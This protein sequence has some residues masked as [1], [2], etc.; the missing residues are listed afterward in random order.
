M[1]GIFIAIVGLPIFAFGIWLLYKSN[2]EKTKRRN[3]FG[4]EQYKSLGDS[5]L[6]DAKVGLYNFIGIVLFSGGGFIT[7]VGIMFA[8]FPTLLDSNSRPGHLSTNAILMGENTVGVIDQMEEESQKNGENNLNSTE[9]TEFYEKISNLLP[10]ICYEESEA[11]RKRN[12][13]CN[14][15]QI[16]QEDIDI[17]DMISDVEASEM[18]YTIAQ[19]DIKINKLIAY[20]ETYKSNRI[21]FLVKHNLSCEEDRVC[22]GIAKLE[23]HVLNSYGAVYEF[24]NYFQMQPANKVDL[25]IVFACDDV[26]NVRCANIAIVQKKLNWGQYAELVMSFRSDLADISQSIEDIR[27][28][29]NNFK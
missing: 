3:A 25:P 10:S 24:K 2:W 21:E 23:Q 1:V 28:A 18:N 9:F 12:A 14:W 4:V 5:I 29:M 19:N 6:S 22:T 26:K 11:L 8:L 16:S 7:G 13:A 17:I 27:F 20:L 15:D